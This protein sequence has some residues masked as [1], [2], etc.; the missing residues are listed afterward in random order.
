MKTMLKTMMA[1][2]AFALTIGNM[3]SA[4]AA[5]YNCRVRG[6]KVTFTSGDDGRRY[7]MSTG[8]ARQAIIDGV[9]L[10]HYAIANNLSKG[11]AVEYI[12]YRA[13]QQAGAI[14][15]PTLVHF[16]GNLVVASAKRELNRCGYYYPASY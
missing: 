7:W 15:Y 14:G 12:M 13:Y 2:A 5:E 1:V 9:N 6:S 11:A 4:S 3:S 16:Y 8:L 10:A